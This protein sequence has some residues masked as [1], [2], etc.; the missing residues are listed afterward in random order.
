MIVVG[1]FLADHGQHG[2][3][4]V[5]VGILVDYMAQGLDKPSAIIGVSPRD[6]T[7][8]GGEEHHKVICNVEIVLP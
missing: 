5:I 1:H 2:E 6:E 7:R 8:K 4:I 3:Q